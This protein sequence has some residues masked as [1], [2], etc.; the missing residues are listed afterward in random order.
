MQIDSRLSTLALA[1]LS[2]GISP[3]LCAQNR[4]ELDDM[5]VTATREAKGAFDVPASVDKVN[6]DTLQSAAGFQVNL[7]DTL[8]RV[9]GLVINNRNNFAQDLQISIRGFGARSTSGVRGVRL[10]ADG[11]PATMP[12]GSGQ[13]SH[14]S[15]S[16]AESIEV[17][18]GP[19]SSLY[20]NSSGGVIQ[21]TT[22][23]PQP[24]QFLE[25]NAALGTDNTQRTGVRFNT[26]SEQFGWLLDASQF[27]TDGYRDHSEAKR[28]NLNS[29]MVW[30]LGRTKVSWLINTVDMPE[31]KD[32]LGLTAEQLQQNRK[33]AGVG[34]VL[35]NSRKSIDQ[36][37]TGIVIEHDYSASTRLTFSPYYGERNIRQVLGSAAVIDLQN[38][39][40]GS[41]IKLRHTTQLL[42]SPLILSTGVTVGELRQNR[43]GNASESAPSNRDEFNTARQ[44]DQYAQA[45]W[46]INEQWA[47]LGGLRNS[48]IDIQSKDQFLSNGDGSG[49]RTY[50][51]I[52]SNLG[53]NF[54]LSPTQ[55]TYAAYGQGFETP[56]LL[57]TAYRNVPGAPNFNPDLNA[58]TSQQFELGYKARYGQSKLNASIYRVET[59]DEI[60][61][62]TASG[63]VTSF[64]NA[65]S[66]QRDGAELNVQ[67]SFSDEFQGYAAM[68]WIDAKYVTSSA[69]IIAGKLLPSIPKQTFYSELTYKP[70]KGVELAGEFRHVGRLFANDENSATVASYNLLN[71]RVS[72][73]HRL[74]EH[75][76]L[77]TYARIDNVSDKK[78][79][80]SVIVNQAAGQFFEPAAERQVMVGASLKYNWK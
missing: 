9:P 50:D 40:Y 39:Y 52:T 15:L 41:D 71:V 61:V 80:G 79:V 31:V 37:Q 7:T 1:L 70:M 28:D 78:Y 69:N 6:Q 12:D 17:L 56:T 24:G 53:V 30:N 16:S 13:I 45:E 8:S 35:R 59:Q 29:K 64:Q 66:T 38:A 51:K 47:L 23:N 19:F 73:I 60:V 18:R 21:I 27:S 49:Q 75:W 4:V 67:H 5:V 72:K 65:G 26:G 54:Y 63:G 11:I 33:Q 55:M 68:N 57:E 34:A 44:L 36:S 46:L 76:T 20:G 32:P 74:D 25:L 48:S 3:T 2:L 77:R 10:I 58:A 14:F 43:R 62:K 22:Q 42:D